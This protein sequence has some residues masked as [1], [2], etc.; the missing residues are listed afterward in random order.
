MA[1]SNTSNF[2]FKHKS[3]GA[4]APYLEIK[5]YEVIFSKFSDCY[6]ARPVNT[7]STIKPLF[8]G[9]EDECNGYIAKNT[10]C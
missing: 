9:T 4:S 5:M 7:H 1:L 10:N 3:T 8:I 2:S 6:I